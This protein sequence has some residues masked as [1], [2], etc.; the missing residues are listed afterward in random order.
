M[1]A[2]IRIG[3]AMAEPQVATSDAKDDTQYLVTLNDF[4]RKYRLQRTEP[5]R[6][7]IDVRY[8]ID[9]NT[10]LPEFDNRNARAYAVTDTLAGGKPLFALVCNPNA[11]QR[12]A[13]ITPLKAISHP[14]IM[15]LLAA[16]WVPLSQPQ[17]ERFVLIYERPQGKKLSELMATRTG[18]V[19]E[20]FLY[21]NIIAPI[22]AAVDQLAIAGITHGSINPDNIYF[23]D[24]P[25][26]GDCISTPCGYNQPFYYEPLERM[27]ALAAGKGDGDPSQDYYALAVIVLYMMYG[28][29]HFAD[30]TPQTLS[31]AI[32]RESAYS[33]LTRNKEFSEV[34]QDFFRGILCV[35]AEDRWT[36]DQIKSWLE[37]RR[38]NVL[39]APPTL[40]S[41]PFEF[42]EQQANTKREL[43]HILYSN[44]ARIPSALDN[45]QLAQWITVSL[46]NK[47]L[48]EAVARLS[49]SAMELGGKNEVQ[50]GEQLMRLLLLLDL[51]GPIRIGPLSMHVD[52]ISSMCAE[53]FMAKAEKDLYLLARFI[54]FNMVSFWLDLQRKDP[55]Y[56]IPNSV[57]NT[58]IKL[59]KL[60]SCIR[61]TGFGFG[62]ERMLYDLN[63]ELP[64]QSPLFANDTVVSLPSLL[65]HLDQLAPSLAG[66]QDPID[67]HIS[68]Y[69]ASKANMQHEM[70]LH[71]LAA[72]PSL[73]SH[74]GMI[75]LRLL[76][77]AQQK[78]GNLTL[79]GLTH[80]LALRIAPALETLRSRSLRYRLH[81]SLVECAQSGS[82]Q[83]L[84]E[85]M[86][87]PAYAEAD[88][89]GFEQAWHLF[90]LNA[91]RIAQYRKGSNVDQ[92]CQ[93]LGLIMSKA[94]A[95][96]ALG[97]TIFSVVKW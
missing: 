88:R 10:P 21:K 94:L 13:L 8:Q 17:Q 22:A 12:H 54:E 25:V 35:N 39:L 37:G 5:K 49:K 3:L 87:N 91:L 66:E 56:T 40:A 55:N 65:V 71:E 23:S 72:L 67:R 18:A 32:M 9:V 64:C 11:V 60:R 41:R 63:P 69:I 45:G 15:K 14:G 93:E 68:A 79:P 29:E 82:L 75:A 78:T 30:M 26:L 73:A 19:N 90:Q 6:D 34:F 92:A 46:R 27:Q 83:M 28:P 47:E 84:A 51:A 57:N 52:G 38:Y 1:A 4:F 85:T 31:T 42:A 59:D 74:R 33:A 61:N 20:T 81:L 16:G 7:V 80:W 95:F 86:I 62:L 50:F 36:Y 89:N 76:A 2:Y 43:A 97:I 53:L 77:L 44:W 58:L 24:M 70:K 48:G 96:L